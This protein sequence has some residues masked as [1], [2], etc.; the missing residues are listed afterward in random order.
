MR[1]WMLVCIQYFLPHCL[2]RDFSLEEDSDIEHKLNSYELVTI[3]MC[4]GANVTTVTA[5]LSSNQSST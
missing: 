1:A 5:D 4:M 2:V 3:V